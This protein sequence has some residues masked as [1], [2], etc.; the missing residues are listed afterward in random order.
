MGNAS[1][2]NTSAPQFEM[3]QGP[4]D[5]LFWDDFND[6][7][8]SATSG[9]AR[10]TLLETAGGATELLSL[11]ET[12]GVLELTQGATDNDVISL[13]ANAG[14][15]LSDLKAGE[16]IRF[17]CRF[18]VTDAD[19][20]DIHIGLGIHDTSYVVSAPADY[21][22]FRLVDGDAGID[23]VISKD[24]S[25][26]IVDDFVDATDATYVRAFFEYFPS[27]VTDIG[28]VVY[29]VHSGG[30]RRRGE[31]DANGNFPDDVVVFPVIQF[32]NGAASADVANV[33]WIYAHAI[34]NEYVNGT[35]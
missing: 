23:L 20:C 7:N 3:W 25:T 8:I 21:I 28:K 12:G 27:T 19:D 30:V 14:F 24:S 5:W 2:F 16:P 11:T 22:A 18:K 35:G 10:W 4:R 34:R 1:N 29:D 15:K 13:I 32:Q 31:V 9:L 6:L 17:G 26:T 33:D